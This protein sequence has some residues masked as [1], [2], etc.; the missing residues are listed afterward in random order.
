MVGS[1]GGAAT[2]GEEEEDARLSGDDQQEG[3][4]FFPEILRMEFVAYS[5]ITLNIYF[6]GI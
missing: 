3:D 5:R 2:G 4:D 6:L 1:R